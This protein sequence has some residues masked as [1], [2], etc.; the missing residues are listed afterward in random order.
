M[1][2]ALNLTNSHEQLRARLAAATRILN[3]AGILDYSGHISARIPGTDLFF[4]QTRSESR[5]EVTPGSVVLCDLDCKVLEGKGKPPSETVIHTEILRSRPDVNAVIH[6]H[7]DLAIAFT[8]MK[9]V[10]I[11]PMR[12]RANR[13]ES[14][15]P[16]H[17][18]PSHIKKLP[19][20]QALAKTL[21]PHHAA[22]M[23]G[24]GMILA[25]ESVPALVTDA[26]HFKE[27]AAAQMQVLSAGQ[28]PAPLSSAEM[29]A[30]NALDERDHH[31]E[32]LWN[33][34]VNKAKKGGTVPASWDIEL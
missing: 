2:T 5:E 7:M 21:G 18:D 12:S 23:R 17:P 33:Y 14:G 10:K 28:T 13:W 24:H 16:V 15:I 8:M 25:A 31:I 29:A 19:Q 27:N 1:A 4:I 26:I 30:V 11:L 32:K 34:Y 6:C 9:D 22:L 3:M 20:G